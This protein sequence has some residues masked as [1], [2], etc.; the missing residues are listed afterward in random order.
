MPR[1]S[2]VVFACMA[3]TLAIVPGCTR[4]KMTRM[5]AA[6][7]LDKGKQELRFYRITVEGKSSNSKTNLQAGFFDAGALH[8]LFGEAAASDDTTKQS[9]PANVTL[10]FDPVTGRVQNVDN[11]RR[12]TILWGTNADAIAG[13]LSMFANS[14]AQGESLSR[15]LAAAAG[16]ETYAALQSSKND[17]ERAKKAKEASA[18]TLGKLASETEGKNAVESRKA[19]LE[20]IEAMI[21]DAGGS[22]TISTS[23][24]A[25]LDNMRARAEDVLKTLKAG[26]KP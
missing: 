15:L 24:A 11:N 6:A 12:F 17:A 14:Q 13:Q 26:A 8:G 19:I 16:Q 25:E 7:N 21:N 22:V 20:A 5:F 10:T 3:T 23:D 9:G 18:S 1:F 2:I 4:S